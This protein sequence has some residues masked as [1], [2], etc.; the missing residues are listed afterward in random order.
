MHPAPFT[1]PSKGPQAVTGGQERNAGCSF[2][3]Y[4]G[5]FCFF[6]AME[7][8]VP[9]GKLIDRSWPARWPQKA[10][11]LTYGLNFGLPEKGRRIFAPARNLLIK[12]L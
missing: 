3:R 7:N 12:A 6:N 9:A 11:T 8:A 10:T 4:Y 2:Y 1:R 5:A